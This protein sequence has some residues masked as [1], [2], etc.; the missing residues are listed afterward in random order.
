MNNGKQFEK[1]IKLIQETFKDSEYTDVFS[2]YQIPNTSG[3]NREID[4]FIASKIN[5]FE[6]NI[7][8]ECKDYKG[9]ISVEKIE[10]FYGKCE[11]INSINKKIFISSNGFQKDAINAAKEFGIELLTAEV[12]TK[13][14]ILKLIPVR[15]IKPHFTYNFSSIILTFDADEETLKKVHQ[16][17]PNTIYSKNDA[18]IESLKQILAEAVNNNRTEIFN[19]ALL[20][21]MTIKN[22]NSEDFPVNFSLTF[23]NSYIKTEDGIRIDLLKLNCNT[24][25]N[26]QF[27]TPH[28]L[29]GRTLKDDNGNSIANAINIKFNEKME[30]EII[31]KNEELHFYSTD[32]NKTTKLQTLL[33]YDNKTGKFKNED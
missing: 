7:A 5:G 22:Y 31:I 4:V 17:C 10:A 19:L 30:S 23:F 11:R 3:R 1:T 6:I 18:N 12:L 25:I 15:Q 27:V 16:E 9:K 13:D 32:N 14:Y 24:M 29:T 33:T 26:F 21:W 20:K 28:T 2:N 8:I